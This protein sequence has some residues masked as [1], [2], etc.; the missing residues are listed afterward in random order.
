MRVALRKRSSATP[1]GGRARKWALRLAAPMLAALASAPVTALEAVQGQTV[2]DRPRPSYD[3]LGVRAGGFDLFPSVEAGQRHDDNIYRIDDERAERG[4]PSDWVTFMRPR[5]RAQS[6]WSNHA[7]ALDAGAS[8]NRFRDNEGENNTDWFAVLSGR[9]DLGRDTEFHATAEMR[10]LRESRGGAY[11]IAGGEPDNFEA[12]TASLGWR[13]RLNRVS[14]AVDGRYDDYA[15]DNP[16]RRFR[17][18]SDLEWRGQTG[19]RLAPGYEA[20]L[21]ATRFER[22]YDRSRGGVDRDSD[23]WEFAVG[24]DLDLGGLVFGELFAG[25]RRQSYEGEGLRSIERPS[26]GASLD[27]NV[28]PLTTISAHAS[29]SVQ[30]TVL[31][32]S[33]V[34]ATRAGA[35]VA[36]E[37]MRN[38]VV[39][40]GAD[41]SNND[42]EVAAGDGPHE[43]DILGGEVGLRW[44]ANRSLHVELSYRYET[45][46]ST[47]PIDNYDNHVASL[48]LT[49]Q[50]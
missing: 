35:G 43:G 9:L 44:F 38:L 6:R 21:R 27:W 45:R 3:A 15:Y 23:G 24:V 1:P 12:R 36:H 10:D 50:L 37:L 33:G 14:L 40:A 31:N 29:R 26:F 11:S 30:E 20:F 25:Y 7:L 5:I 28:T 22:R 18:R 8:V 13:S 41:F 16:T 32:A 19:Y 47:L 49:L 48:T 46:D 17:D 39:T 34:L 42:Y 4:V 2:Q